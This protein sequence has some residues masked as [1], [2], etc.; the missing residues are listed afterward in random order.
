MRVDLGIYLVL[1]AR[2]ACPQKDLFEGVLDVSGG[3]VLD[4][5]CCKLCCTGTFEVPGGWCPTTCQAGRH[6]SWCSHTLP[7]LSPAPL[8]ALWP[9]RPS[10]TEPPFSCRRRTASGWPPREGAAASWRPTEQRPARGRPSSS[11]GRRREASSYGRGQ[12]TTGAWMM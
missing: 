1:E 12:G 10:S 6:L 7:P 4:S 5:Q 9:C 11:G 8:L 2:R 3:E